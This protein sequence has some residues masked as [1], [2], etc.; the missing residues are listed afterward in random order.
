MSVL[1]QHYL[2]LCMT[3]LF[4]KVTENPLFKAFERYSTV[5]SRTEKIKAYASFVNEIYKNGGSLTSLVCRLVFEDEN[6]YVKSVAAGKAIDQNIVR[7]AQREF[8]AFVE[9]V[10]KLAFAV[11]KS[12]ESAE[13]LYRQQLSET[14]A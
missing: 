10:D 5:E 11:R 1:N 13:K 6:V 12:L 4:S 14:F 2:K 9:K 7:S 3:T 8:A